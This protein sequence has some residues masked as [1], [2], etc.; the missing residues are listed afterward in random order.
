L[1]VS[2]IEILYGFDLATQPVV[3]ILNISITH[4]KSFREPSDSK[5]GSRVSR[6]SVESDESGERRDEDQDAAVRRRLHVR[7]NGPSYVHRSEKVD[8]HLGSDLKS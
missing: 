6:E 4:C 5:L 2:T 1:I 3:N 8:L 7:K